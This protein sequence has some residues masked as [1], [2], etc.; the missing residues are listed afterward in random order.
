[1]PRAARAAAGGRGCGRPP[2]RPPRSWG[3]GVA[4]GDLRKDR[5][6]GHAQPRHPALGIGRR[7][8]VA[9]PAHPPG[10]AGVT[11]AFDC[12]PDEGALSR[13]GRR[14]ARGG[15]AKVSR[16]RRMARRNSAQSHGSD[17]QLTR[18][19]HRPPPAR[20]AAP[21][22]ARGSA[23]ARHAPESRG[24]R[25]LPARHGARLWAG[26]GSGCPETP[27][28]RPGAG[29]RGSRPCSRR[30]A[31]AGRAA[32]AGSRARYPAAAG[33]FH[34]HGAPLLDRRTGGPGAGHRQVWAYARRFQT[35]IGGRP[36]PPAPNR[37]LEGADPPLRLA[38]V[39]GRRLEPSGRARCPEGVEK[40]ID[41]RPA[42]D[43]NGPVL[44]APVTEAAMPAFHPPQ[45]GQHIGERPVLGAQ[46]CPCVDIACMP[47]D[48][49]HGVDR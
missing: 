26:N 28:R 13:S 35:G 8:R 24:C 22:R 46:R 3:I 47:A 34:P 49:D 19:A 44:S 25:P 18:R 4:V 6:V 41:T 30:R 31:R 27:P 15:W 5:A 45:I 43:V 36:A 1:M 14:G 40:R 48:T 38:V 10:A 29:T 20:S 21:A 16:T 17:M 12:R 7:H 23:W 33:D 9:G 11:A 39:I 42:A 32:I 37:C 2:S